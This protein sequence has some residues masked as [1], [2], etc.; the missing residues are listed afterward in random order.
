[1]SHDTPTYV[2]SR[3]DCA[4]GIKDLCVRSLGTLWCTFVCIDLEDLSYLFSMYA[5]MYVR[6]F[7][8]KMHFP[9]IT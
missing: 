1:M 2:G 8:L 6:M 4:C 7:V 9:V 5:C 3:L